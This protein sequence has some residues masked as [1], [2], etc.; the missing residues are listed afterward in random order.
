MNEIPVL[1]DRIGWTRKRLSEEVGASEKTIQRWCNLPP[2]KREKVMSGVAY[3][4]TVRYLE[5]VARV[6]GV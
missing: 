1:L 3:S 6:L 2:T 4:A 5:M